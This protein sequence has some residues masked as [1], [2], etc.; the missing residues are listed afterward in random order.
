[1]EDLQ[2]DITHEAASA[3]CECLTQNGIEFEDRTPRPKP[4]QIFASGMEILSILGDATPYAALAAVIIAWL[5]ANSRRKVIITTR[6]Y[7]VIHIEGMSPEDI[8]RVL[9]SAKRVTMLDI[10]EKKK[11]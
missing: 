4:G 1:M 3:F 8:D 5:K 9:T 2:I 11:K 7:K 10:P 6:D